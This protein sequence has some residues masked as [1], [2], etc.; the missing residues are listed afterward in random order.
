MKWQDENVRYLTKQMQLNYIESELKNY[1]WHLA[2][3]KI[4]DDEQKRIEMEYE[5][6]LESPRI[7]GSIIKMP[8]GSGEKSPWQLDMSGKIAELEDKKNVEKQ[9]LDQVDKW[10]K[11]CTHSQEKMIKQYIMIQQC[12]DVTK[13]ARETGYSEDNVKKSR[14]RVLNKIFSAYFLKTV[15]SVTENQ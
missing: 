3:W 8:Q 2:Q 1:Y 14:E 5:S 10:M 7:S 12:K 11:V 4:Y 13:A 6:L 15:H 9:Y